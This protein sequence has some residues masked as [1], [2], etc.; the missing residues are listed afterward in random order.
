[1]DF[2]P[3][4]LTAL[5]QDQ[6][7][8]PQ[9]SNSDLFY[10]DMSKLRPD[11]IFDICEKLRL[12]WN[13]IGEDPDA[14]VG[15]YCETLVSLCT[16]IRKRLDHYGEPYPR[17]TAISRIVG[18]LDTFP[19]GPG[20]KTKIVR[21][22]D[23]LT[24]I[25]RKYGCAMLVH[26]E[27]LVYVIRTTKVRNVKP[28]ILGVFT[29]IDSLGT[30]PIKELVLALI[31]WEGADIKLYLGDLCG[32][33]QASMAHVAELAALES[34]TVFDKLG[35]LEAELLTAVDTSRGLVLDHLATLR[36]DERYDASIHDWEAGNARASGHRPNELSPAVGPSFTQRLLDGSLGSVSRT[37]KRTCRREALYRIA[38]CLAA[39][40][41]VLSDHDT[42]R[43]LT[44]EFSHMVASQAEEAG[45][46]SNASSHVSGDGAG[47]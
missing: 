44:K 36:Q 27:A 7:Q 18:V 35:A 9:A 25:E 4:T 17:S 11:Q 33:D 47:A 8:A 1:M 30:S 41:T 37:T 31:G 12:V 23:S 42:V 38:S 22:R 26:L 32:H 2:A 46:P 28:S 40:K 29:L 15:V 10:F 5:G 3:R 14:A 34:L 20:N 13:E 19:G 39:V 6:S 45:R 21:I 16:A 43:K 24:G